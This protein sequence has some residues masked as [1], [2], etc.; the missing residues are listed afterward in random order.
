M[1]L[2][3]FGG[4]R[5]PPLLFVTCPC[6]PLAVE[7]RYFVSFA[8][9]ATYPKADALRESCRRGSTRSHPR[10]DGQPVSPAAAQEA[11]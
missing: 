1:R 7:R 8:G 9:N 6:F 11:W 10:G 2:T 4:P 3:P 5:R